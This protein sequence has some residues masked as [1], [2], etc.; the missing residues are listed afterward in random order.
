MS[1]FCRYCHGDS[2]HKMSCDF[3]LTVEEWKELYRTA[4]ELNDETMQAELLVDG[5][6][7]FETKRAARFATEVRA[8]IRKGVPRVLV[9]RKRHV[10]GIGVVRGERV[11]FKDYIDDPPLDADDK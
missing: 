10:L 11:L 1:E 5:E 3:R 7:T 9:R 4:L 6:R 2:Y 8:A